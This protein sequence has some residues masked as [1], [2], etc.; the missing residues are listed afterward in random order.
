[1]KPWLKEITLHRFRHVQ[2]GTSL[3]FHPRF[4]VL[5]G[6]NA[7]GKTTLLNLIS[8]VLRGDYSDYNEEISL[9]FVFRAGEAEL[10]GFVRT[11]PLPPLPLEPFQRKELLSSIKPRIYENLEFK[12]D[13]SSWSLS[14]EEEENSFFLKTNGVTK[15]ISEYA[16]GRA[17]LPFALRTSLSPEILLF[18]SSL[19]SSSPIRHR[20]DLHYFDE[21]NRPFSKKEDAFYLQVT[22]EQETLQTFQHPQTSLLKFWADRNLTYQIYERDIGVWFRDPTVVDRWDIPLLGV[23]SKRLG[24]QETTLRYDLTVEV[25]G[26]STLYKLTNQLFRFKKRDGSIIHHDFLSYGQKR[27]LSLLVYLEGNPAFVVIDEITNGLH[28]EWIEFCMEELEKRQSFLASQSPLLLDYLWFESAEEARRSFFLCEKHE[29]SEKES[30]VWR[31]MSE[32]EAEDFYTSF[33]AG[34]QHVSEVLRTKGL[35]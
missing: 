33:E 18:L 28:H 31:Q 1:M 21:I 9:D 24:F 15:K 6:K 13:S 29:G 12:Q 32:E 5:L 10:R 35:W 14:F 20:E 3:R 2:P 17:S 7:T 19:A 34:L 11:R 27:M 30:L 8:A 22:F 16:G 23:I 26:G 4:N 25:L